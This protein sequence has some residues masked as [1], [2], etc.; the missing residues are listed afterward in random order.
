MGNACL[1]IKSTK[2][3]YQSIN[4]DSSN[5]DITPHF[6]ITAYIC[7]IER[8]LLNQQIIPDTIIDLCVEYYYT[9]IFP[10]FSFQNYGKLILTKLDII[11]DKI[12]N[13]EVTIESP[14]NCKSTTR[15]SLLSQQSALLHHTQNIPV[16]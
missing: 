1:P 5:I 15:V 14:P 13:Y 4:S 16:P 8:T 11:D 6:V 9:E 7:K 10:I 12:Q 3:K 2:T